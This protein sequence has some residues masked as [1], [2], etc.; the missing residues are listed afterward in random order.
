[1]P[2][3]FPAAEATRHPPL[4]GCDEVGR[5]ALCGPVVV[6]AVYFDPCALPPALLEAL[7]D[8]KRLKR[9]QREAVAEALPAHARLAFAASG[10]A[11][12]DASDIRQATL[13]AMARAVRRLGLAAPVA[14]DGRDIPPLLAGR[15]RAVV[16]GDALVPQIAAASILAKVLRDRLM[17]RLHAR[18]PDYGWA[19]NVGYGTAA[20]LAALGRCGPTRHHRHSFTPVG[21]AAFRSVSEPRLPDAMREPCEP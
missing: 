6:A 12:I 11:A 18:Y 8:S 1:M 13:A 16:G 7:D 9:A 4:I 5:G 2:I 21:Q 17:A 15:C 3:R 10:A 14:V 20:H 19:G